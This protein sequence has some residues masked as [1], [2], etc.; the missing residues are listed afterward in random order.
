ML[1]LCQSVLCALAQ[2]SVIPK[3]V[4][5]HTGDG[6]FIIDN[7][8]QLIAPGELKNEAAFLRQY[9]Q[10]QSGIRLSM[11]QS[12]T[13]NRY[14]HL[15][16]DTAINYKA[17]SYTL[18]IT[19]KNIT[20]SA[21]DAAGVLYGLQTIRQLVKGN[22]KTLQL[23]VCHITDYPR[24]AYRGMHLDVSRHFFSVDFIKQ[25]IDVLSLYKF[26]TFHWHLT[27]DQGWRIEIK[28]YPG[29]QRM[30]AWRDGTL[31]GHK[32]E[33]P[34]TFDNKKYGGY[35][36]QEEVKAVVRYAAEKH[37]TI[38][39]EIEMPGHALAA[40][41]AYPSLGC[42]G[43]PYK[44]AKFWGV[45]D[46]VFCAG[47]DSTFTFLQ[48]V[49][50]EVAA[51]FPSKYIHIGGDECPKGKWNQ[52]PKCLKRMKEEHLSDAHELQSYFVKRIEKY[53]NSKGKQ[54]IGWDEILEGGLSP[55]AT[56]MS[57]RGEEGGI[58][59]AQQKHDVIMAPE[60]HVYFDYYQ[61]LYPEEQLA[62]G[63]YTPLSKVYSY[64]PMAGV[65]EDSIRTYLKGVQGEVWS[66]YL[67]TVAKAQHAI[68][69]RLIA[70]GEVAW[71]PQASRNY[72]DFLSRL[73]LQRTL[74][75]KLNI[76]AADV[77]DEINY[78]STIK[79]NRVEVTL[80]TT[81]PNGR[82]YYTTDG[83]V[84]TP[85]S[86]QYSGAF[87]LAKNAEVKAVLFDVNKQYGR[88]F[89]Q[90]FFV[91]K[92]TGKTVTI[93]QQPI[94][95]FNTNSSALVNGI[96]GTT[97]YNDNQWLGF[98]GQDCEAIIDLGA[99]TP[100]S[101]IKMNVLNYHWQ[102]MWQPDLVQFLVSTDGIHFNIIYTA[103]SFPVNGINAIEATFK[104]VNARY[105][106]VIA[107][108]KGI[109]PGGEYGAGEQALLLIDE[110]IVQ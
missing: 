63:G 71:S 66:E 73:R 1:L 26:N 2:Y 29:L 67:P 45:F 105:V 19:T 9:V 110:I 84:P 27:D 78:T 85:K 76:A 3:P 47:N 98:K 34:H 90:A 30:G 94:A 48:N 75:E 35:Y 6:V 80:T 10:A 23:P 53:L 16:I 36:T 99:A 79:D 82:I 40:L 77:F 93:K 4:A 22:A 60:S 61:S 41:A 96:L 20:L 83:T 39:P 52:C 57:W 14:I 54:A 106:K 42:T 72:P 50:D 28:K 89:K 86:Q 97:R 8:T 44:T 51:L 56:V 69:P 74:L 21:H 12:A 38:I 5:M 70:L 58:A 18:D 7:N 25:Y 11:S 88:L 24:F 17:E 33:L 15:L 107:K 109:I 62:A 103:N 108:N 32:K 104:A 92:A 64:E 102:K 55:N 95:R 49:L 37:I 59:A 46:D 91:Y 43:G 68:F 13:S 65:K 31:I 101:N 87:T 81:L 100:V